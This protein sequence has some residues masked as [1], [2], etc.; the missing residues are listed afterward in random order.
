MM[1]S[2]LI[3][4]DEIFIA[5]KIKA[6]VDWINIG[7]DKVFVAHN[8]RQAKELFEQQIIDIMICDIEMPQGNGI[9]L[10]SW[11]KECK[12][13]TETI[14]LTCH[15]DFEYTKKA[16]QL[17]SLD[18]L[19]KPVQSSELE[20]TVCKAIHKLNIDRPISIERFWLDILNQAV[21]S[22]LDSL[23]DIVVS[24]SIP[25][26]K[27]M[28]FLPILISIQYWKKTLTRREEYMME[29]ALSKTAEEI[30]V[31]KAG[32]QVIRFQK[33][34]LL[35]I[36]PYDVSV[37]AVRDDL[38]KLLESYIESCNQFFYCELSCYVGMPVYMNNMMNMAENLIVAQ[39][40]NVSRSNQVI[41][42]EEPTKVEHSIPLPSM[43]VWSEMLKQGKEAQLIAEVLTVLDSWRQLDGVDAS[44]IQR[45]YQSFLHMLV[46]TLRQN[47]FSGSDRYYYLLSPERSIIATRS[48]MELQ[49]WIKDLLEVVFNVM[50]QE[51]TSE[52]IVVKIQRYIS[53]HIDEALSRQYIAD[54]I[55]L[56]PD[57]VV[58]LF[59]KET[60]IS[61]SD[62]IVQERM[63]IAKELLA[64]SDLPISS[65]ALTIGY[66]NFAYFSTTF[67][68]EEMMTP[69][70]YRRDHSVKS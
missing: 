1:Y 34:K 39:Q 35:L 24:E 23:M 17:G 62:Y 38:Y 16:I 55:G 40:N 7:I 33:G 42:Y 65:I 46:Y 50:Q 54:Y 19:L 44:T 48:I 53:H 2:L 58:K 27:D 66:S 14:F 3:V 28:K 47:G 51:Q 4:D 31:F 56:S 67:K 11:V 18:Y 20:E 5:N 59:K 41:Y 25:Y 64:K 29:Y 70:E 45:F 8:I 52:S 36:I 32:G 6:S 9:E 15:V 10:L 43:H 61:I 26:T 49:M 68:K 69:Q 60:G 63:R 30:I 13:K 21:P 37:T 22:K 57:Y 12:Y